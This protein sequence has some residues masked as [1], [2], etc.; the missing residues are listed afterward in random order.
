M[1]IQQNPAKHFG[2]DK[3]K[4]PCYNIFKKHLVKTKALPKLWHFIFFKCQTR[5]K[6][7]Q[8]IYEDFIIDE[9]ISF[10]KVLQLQLS[11]YLI[12]IF[13]FL[14]GRISWNQADTIFLLYGSQK[15]CSPIIEYNFRYYFFSYLL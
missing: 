8:R 14:S 3:I 15:T 1:L 9:I 4:K 6:F 2:S 11:V 13:I 5:T 10:S 7:P 12:N